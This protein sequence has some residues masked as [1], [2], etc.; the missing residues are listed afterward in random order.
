[1]QE[2]GCGA[3]VQGSGCGARGKAKRRL[4]M[5]ATPRYFT[6]RVVKEAENRD[7]KIASMNDESRFGPKFHI[8][9]MI[10]VVSPPGPLQRSI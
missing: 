6:N 1:M 3:R 8:I 2:L 9:E 7:Y 5:T 4:F 10:G